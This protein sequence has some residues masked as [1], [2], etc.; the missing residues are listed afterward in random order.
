MAELYIDGYRVASEDTL[1]CENR[2]DPNVTGRGGVAD[3]HRVR[4][5]VVLLQESDDR[6]DVFAR[7]QAA[8]ADHDN[9]C[10]F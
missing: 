10:D 5:D 1:A 2:V 9:R 4:G 7:G 6:R 3:T 8:V